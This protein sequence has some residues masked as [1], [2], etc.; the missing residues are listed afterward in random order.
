MSE[1]SERDQPAYPIGSVDKALRLLVLVTEKP[2]GVRIGDAAGALGVAPSTA[3]R[4]LQMLA[5][6]GF[7]RQ[8]SDTK[9]YH[10]G[11]ALA[12]LTNPG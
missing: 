12:R 3:H 5:L 10:P 11:E 4:L 2:G 6:H 1:Q 7:A 8:D 9:A